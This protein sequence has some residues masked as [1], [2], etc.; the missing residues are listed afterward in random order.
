MLGDKMPC[1]YV[2]GVTYGVPWFSESV[3]KVYFSINA[4]DNHWIL[5]DFHIRSDI[6]PVND[7]KPSA[8]VHLTA[9]HNV[10][11]NEQQHTNQ[12]EPSYDT[13]LLEK[14]DSNTTPD[15][16]NMCH[17]R[18]EIDQDVEQD[19]I[20]EL[21]AQ[22]QAKNLTINNLKKQIKNM[23]E[24]SN[25]AKVKHDIDI[26]ETIN[27][28]LEHEVAKL[29]KEN[30]TLKM[31]YKD[32]YDSI[33]VMKT[34]T[35]EQT[36]SLI[37]KNDEFKAQLQ[38]KGFTIAALKNK[39][40][41]LTGNN[42]NIKFAKPSILGKPVLQPLRNQSVIRQ[43]TAFRSE[44]P[45][46]SKPRW[47]PTGRIFKTAGLRWIPTGKIFTECTT[48][49]DSDP[50]NGSNEDI[51]NPYE[52]DQTLNVSAGLVPQPPSLTPNL[53]PTKNDW[54]T[55]FYPL[56]DEYFNPPPRVVSL[57]SA[58]VAASRAVDPAG[59]LSS[60]TIDQDVPLSSDSCSDE[61]TL[62]GF[63]PSNLHHLKQSFGTLTMLT[64]NYPLENVIGDPSR[65]LPYYCH[66]LELTNDGT[67]THIETDDEDRFK[68]VF[69]SFG[70][71][72]THLKGR[73]EG[74]NLLTVRMD[75]NN[76]IIPI[77]TGV[78][79]AGVERW[80]RAYC[81]R[82]R[83]NYMTS[84]SAESINSLTRDV[85]IVSITNLIEWYK[86]LV[87]GWYC[88]RQEKYKDG[89]LDELSDWAKAKI[90]KRMQKS[91][92]WVFVGIEVGKVYE[93]DDRRRI[94]T[95]KLCNGTCTCRKWKVLLLPCGHVLAI[96][97]VIGLTN[98]NRFAKGW[99]KRIGL[100]DQRAQNILDLKV[101]NRLQSDVEGSGR[102]VTTDKGIGKAFHTQKKGRIL[103]EAHS[104]QMTTYRN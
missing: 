24:K 49:V 90:R 92:N 74:T 99:F 51:T 4:E 85:R 37:A 34:K 2:D 22:L 27:I 103:E 70:V 101:R 43:L 28:E 55:V 46:F 48:K 71:V 80:S 104:K 50:P 73:Y 57:V 40:R 13:Y 62:Q 63:I 82:D 83:Y 5:A 6:R 11:A 91:L 102:M 81:P 31:H 20:N 95:V 30:E 97:R 79:Q 16:T 3:K 7:Q 33:K 12:S 29:R 76:Q 89:P 88:E 98:C 18:G 53:P 9:Q 100:K 66:N 14:I 86:K 68:M 56:F 75:G 41:K 64:K 94:Q 60:T 38:E 96:C 8:E 21:K 39:L 36:T 59:S 25:E 42:V 84:N 1:Y 47:K 17:R 10:L 87:Q 45:K 77:A 93:V 72:V 65:L 78:S 58:A 69:I 32:L 15:S 23:H 67:V 44:R 54:D 52:C 61:T 26:I 19:Q 35:I